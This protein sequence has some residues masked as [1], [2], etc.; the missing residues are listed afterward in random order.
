MSA[1]V[2]TNRHPSDPD[3]VTQGVELYSSCLNRN[4]ERMFALWTKIVQSA[5]VGDV[6]R[7][8]TLAGIRAANLTNSIADS[9]HM[10]AMRAAGS[11]LSAMG[12]K[13]ELLGGLTQV[14]HAQRVAREL[15]TGAGGRVGEVMEQLQ[16]KLL[17]EGRFR[18]VRP[19]VAG[20]ERAADVGARLARSDAPFT[21]MM[22]PAPR[23][24]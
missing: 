12:A 20:R 13:M 5:R 8:K 17:Q 1:H 22:W 2:V 23:E 9:G 19:R 6:Q 18:C 10:Y 7:L 3:A 24:P 4:V 16:H 14:N 11:R 15:S 21:R